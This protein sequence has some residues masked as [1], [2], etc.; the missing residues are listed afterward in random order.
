MEVLDVHSF[1]QLTK[2]WQ[3]RAKLSEIE[4]DGRNTT[5]TSHQTCG[6]VRLGRSWNEEKE[7]R[8]AYQSAHM[9]SVWPSSRLL[10]GTDSNTYY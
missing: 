4:K 7:T 5:R 8:I 10:R 1:L 2:R 6:F 9:V 3:E